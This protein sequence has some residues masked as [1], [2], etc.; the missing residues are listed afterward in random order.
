VAARQG[1]SAPSFAQAAAAYTEAT[2]GSLSKASVA[3]ITEGFGEARAAQKAQ[4]AERAMA[5]SQVGESPRARRV[6]LEAPITGTGNVSS[7]GVMVLV[8][9]EGWKEA[10]IAAFSA[11][12]VLAPDSGKRRRAQREGQRADKPIVRLK[13]HSY[14]VGLWD[15]ETFG[16]HQYAEGLRRG[17]ERLKRLS[18]VNDGAPWIERITGENF[19]QAVQI[20]DWGHSVQR[21]WL[22]GNAVYGEG[23]PAAAAW[24]NARQ[25]ELWAGEVAQVV[26]SLD[27]LQLHEGTYADE[28][29]RTPGYFDHNR[30]RMRYADFRALGYPIGSGTVESGAKNVVQQRM[31]RPGRG[32]N[33]AHAQ[34]MLAA[35]AD[36]HSERF[37]W[38]WQQV[39][40]PA[41]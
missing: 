11:V 23:K 32:W 26:R 37:A 31:K 21:L 30:N 41:A 34:G 3:R 16:K 10:K 2:G 27:A 35:L 20:V 19:G 12:E 38:A 33:R 8:R 39:Y 14:C 18:S 5:V 15:A 1:L 22:V 24:V 40:H 7:D 6:A 4:E 28:V 9:D 29:K 13:A 36:L 25:D 17:L